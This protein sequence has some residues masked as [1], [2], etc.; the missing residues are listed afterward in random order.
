MLWCSMDSIRRGPGRGSNGAAHR[1]RCGWAERE[2]VPYV[3]PTKKRKVA[4]PKKPAAK[5]KKEAPSP[6]PRAA[7][8]RPKKKKKRESSV[9]VQREEAP[10]PAESRASSFGTQRALRTA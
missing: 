1:A 4:A 6:S 9:V 10:D 8:P 5:K 7:A 2:G 3:E